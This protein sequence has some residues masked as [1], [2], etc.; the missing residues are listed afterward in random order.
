MNLP[1]FI[2]Y[3]DDV[4]VNYRNLPL[5]KL[6]EIYESNIKE[7]RVLQVDKKIGN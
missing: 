4:K 6:N 1:K 2:K 3:G 7:K 5:D